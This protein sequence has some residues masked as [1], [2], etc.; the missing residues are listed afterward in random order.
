MNEQH[1]DR[2]R[3]ILRAN[4]THL[5]LRRPWIYWTDL[6]GTAVIAWSALVGGCVALTRGAVMLATLGF[7]VAVFAFYRASAFLHEV[8]HMRDR[9]PGF[10]LVWNLLVGVPLL[11]PSFIYRGVHTVHHARAI[12]GTPRDPEYVEHPAGL[13]HHAKLLVGFLLLP[14]ALVVRWL[15]LA[16]LSMCSAAL[17]RRVIEKHSSLAGNPDFVRVAPTGRDRRRWHRLEIACSIWS[18]T[19]VGL[20]ASGCL[21]RSCA[22]FV[23]ALSVCLTAFHSLRSLT[24]HRFHGAG[25]P[26]T[27]EEQFLDSVNVT[28][29]SVWTELL[30]PVGLRY[31]ALHHFAP[32]LPYHA[33]AA[34]HR[35]LARDLPVSDPYH[36]VTFSSFRQI[37]SR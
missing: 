12:F 7:V 9:I 21:P 27:F 19:L 6:L 37:P 17:R 28:G 22:L 5:T 26:R 31:H 29:T 3:A 11:T 34:A 25:A 16:P 36:T 24:A 30:A 1:L 20:F 33:L 15:V 10:D 2:V 14:V 8:A 13:G 18:A 32:D 23:F 4:S 35:L